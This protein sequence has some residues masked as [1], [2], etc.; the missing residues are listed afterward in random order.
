MT[1][2]II[3]ATGML[4][5]PVTRTLLAAGYTV[6]I[7]ARHVAAAKRLFPAAEVVFGD[8]KKPESLPAA[9][10]GCA[11]T[12]LSL[13]VRQTEKPTDFHTETDGLRHLLAAAKVAGVKRVAYLSSIVMR[14]QSMN[15]FN[16]WVFR[17]KHEAVALIKA[18]GLDY[19]IF[20]P[21]NFMETM[22]TTQRMGPL[23]L[24]VGS[25]E[26]KPWFISAKNYG[27][28][29]ARALQI[30]Q[31]GQP[32]EYVIQGPEPVTQL[33]AAQ[34]LAVSYTRSK[35]MVLEIPLAMLRFGQ[36]VSQ[37]ADYGVHIAEALNSYPE[38]FEAERTWPH[39]G[40]T[41]LPINSFAAGAR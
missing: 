24:V 10:A 4:G 11:V 26:V 6:R 18:S 16:W 35:L 38:Q 23:V 27:K 5:Q 33:T 41:T 20:Y 21:S 8:L 36:L 22:L 40:K 39:L 7:I 28:Q 17:I 34:R 32:Q 25:S 14:Y 15:G 2:A 37:Q 3:G 12:Y 29:V 31:A 19:S 13:S 1:I 9:L 30:A